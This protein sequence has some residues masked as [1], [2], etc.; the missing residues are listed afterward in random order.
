MERYCS[1]CGSLVSGNAA[2][3]PNCGAPLKSAVD[4][5]KETAQQQ[6]QYPQQNGYNGQYGQPMQQNQQYGA[7]V[8]QMTTGQWVGTILLTTC[9]SMVSLILTIVW[10]FGYTTPEPKKS[11]CKALFFVQLISIGLAIIMLIILAAI[12]FNFARYFQ[13]SGS[14]WWYDLM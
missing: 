4:L 13:Q 1:Q 9:F 12:G 10:G 3:C 8:Q 2:H 7:P 14:S 11:Y 6:P 5:G